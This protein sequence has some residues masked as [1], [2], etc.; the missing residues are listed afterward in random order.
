M[1]K[2]NGV[3]GPGVDFR[4]GGKRTAKEGLEGELPRLE[5]IVKPFISKRRTSHLIFF[6]GKQRFLGPVLP[7]QKS[8]RAVWALQ[9]VYGF[10]EAYSA[11][12]I[13]KAARMA[14]GY[15][16]SMSE[17]ENLE[18]WGKDSLTVLA[19]SARSLRP[20]KDRQA[21]TINRHARNCLA[22]KKAWDQAVAENPNVRL[23]KDLGAAAAKI[24]SKKR[25]EAVTPRQIR[26][27]LKL[28]PKK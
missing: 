7:D 14:A 22:A 11:G 10:L 23:K 28:S 15:Q 20:L 19:A 9:Y 1:A 5:K 27:W 3:T 4:I 2:E 17:V 18:T 26:G 8:W 21:D 13:D 6:Q 16:R 24:L 12:D 25:G